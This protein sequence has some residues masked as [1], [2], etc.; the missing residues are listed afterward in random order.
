MSADAHV[1]AE[2]DP[3][4]SSSFLPEQSS[5][6]S[7]HTVPEQ[8]PGPLYRAESLAAV[9]SDAAIPDTLAPVTANRLPVGAV[10]DIDSDGNDDAIVLCVSKNARDRALSLLSKEI[11]L[12]G[13]E[14][15][16]VEVSLLILRYV[17]SGTFSEPSFS[18]E[19]LKLGVFRVVKDFTLIDLGR[20]MPPAFEILAMNEN[21]TVREWL[22]IGPKVSRLSL[23]ESPK[24]KSVV[25]DID[26]DGVMDVIMQDKVFEEGAGEETFLSW[27]RWN[28]E[29]YT[30]YSSTNIVRNLNSFLLQVSSLIERKNWS[31]FVRYALVSRVQASI[32]E[33]NLRSDQ[34]FRK[35][36]IPAH[37]GISVAVDNIRTIKF[38][39]ILENPF[40]DTG[41]RIQLSCKITTDRE[42]FFS[43][44]VE[45]S[46][47]PFI[48]PQYNLVWN[49]KM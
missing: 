22:I 44:G 40:T 47:N 3:A 17:S 32:N 19:V 43:V 24:K 2:K 21:S 18:A 48:Q 9:L 25:T 35:V 34:V 42:L 16:A 14:Y 7:D 30:E 8:V 31:R 12:Y 38:Q 5:P 49:S 37:S 46:Q 27:Y 23:L 1:S 36:F 33:Q 29:Q 13:D 15:D 20:G 11:R 45:L 39:E 26:N 6:L 41:R 10:V 28:G 4:F